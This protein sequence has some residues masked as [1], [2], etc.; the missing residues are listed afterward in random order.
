MTPQEQQLLNGLFQR[1]RDAAAMP[2]DKDAEA[3]IGEA[4]RQQPYA[5]YLLAQTV[6]IQEEALKAAN[7]HIEELEA[8]LKQLEAQKA[9]AQPTSFL[10]GLFG[11]GISSG[12]R[13]PSGVPS[14]GGATPSA[15]PTA[16][17][18]NTQPRP[19]PAPQA[20]GWSGAAYPQQAYPPQGGFGFGMGGS[21]LGSALATAAGVAGGALLFQGL[22]SAFSGHHASALL[23]QTAPGGA[24][25]AGS[26]P[27]A[28]LPGFPDAPTQFTQLPPERPADDA[29]LFGSDAGIQDASYDDVGSGDDS[30][31]DWT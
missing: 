26:D 2:R 28:G 31:G 30:G 6:L 17:V 9:D 4:V 7:G 5:P 21:F 14:V 23:D 25:F 11:G 24:G 19:Q 20:Q 27:T 3:L 12:G 10:G 1:I 8:R 29:G 18:W 15:Q 13:T 16:G 22:Q